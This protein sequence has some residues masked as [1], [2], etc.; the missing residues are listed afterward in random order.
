VKIAKRNKGVSWERVDR[1]MIDGRPNPEKIFQ[2]VWNQENSQKR[3]L[4]LAQTLLIVSKR[5]ADLFDGP[6]RNDKPVWN[7]MQGEAVCIYDLT[8]REQRIIATIIQWLGTSVGFGFL[9]EVL[10]KSGYYIA[11]KDPPPDPKNK[12]KRKDRYDLLKSQRIN[13]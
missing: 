1:E 11:S 7:V 5:S 2:E 9:H 4:G 6:D 8:E 3:G 13:K 10:G 12:K